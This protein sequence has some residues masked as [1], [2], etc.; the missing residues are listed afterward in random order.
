MKLPQ[1]L[2]EIIRRDIH[3]LTRREA[4]AIA[5]R[6]AVS[7]CLHLVHLG[8]AIPGTRINSVTWKDKHGFGMLEPIQIMQ[9]EYRK[10]KQLKEVA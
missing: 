7:L 4:V 8:F 5:G 9:R 3:F 6:D 1:F 10:Q 2:T